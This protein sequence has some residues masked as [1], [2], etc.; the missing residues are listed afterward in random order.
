MGFA[1]EDLIPTNLRLAA[2]N[3]GAIYFAG[4]PPITV[5]HM[6]SRDL[7]MS[8]LVVEN[9]DQFNL[10]RDLNSLHDIKQACLVPNPN[11]QC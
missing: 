11:S 4:R 5:L 7:R 8:F 10:G 2:T 6:G 9:S 1:R 3:R